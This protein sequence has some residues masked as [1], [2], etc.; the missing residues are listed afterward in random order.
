MAIHVNVSE[1]LVQISDKPDG[2]DNSRT[3]IAAGQIRTVNN[4]RTS[5]R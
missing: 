1:I 5:Q 4:L 2:N 3:C